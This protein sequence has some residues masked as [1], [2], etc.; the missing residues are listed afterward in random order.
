M[1]GR[2]LFGEPATLTFHGEQKQGKAEP[3]ASPPRNETGNATSSNNTNPYSQLS[4]G[5]NSSMA[6]TILILLAALFFMGFFSIYVRR[7]SEDSLEPAR[8]R[9]RAAGAGARRPS[10]S[11]GL[12]PAL[13]RSLPTFPFKSVSPKDE[14]LCAVC[15]GEFEGGET[16]KLLPLCGHF[17]HADCIDEWLSSHTSCPLCRASLVPP[18]SQPKERQ[19]DEPEGRRPP[20]EESSSAEDAGGSRED[21]VPEVVVVVEEAAGSSPAAG[22][23]ESGVRR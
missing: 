20:G 22:E 11:P 4:P 7:F 18:P 19:S 1:P 5:F 8:R 12:D 13:I 17:F 10:S 14:S 21:G 2:R 23:R 9:R 3:P 15:L 16:A 6:V